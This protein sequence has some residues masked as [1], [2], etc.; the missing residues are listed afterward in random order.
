MF[1]A[2]SKLPLMA[3]DKERK[4]MTARNLL[5]GAAVL[6][7]VIGLGPPAKADVITQSLSVGNSAISPYAG[8]Y[9]TLTVDLTS[10]N[11][12]QITFTSDVVDGNIFLMG[13][14]GQGAVALNVN[15]TSFAVSNISG[16]NS[17]TG[18][19]PGPYSLNSPPGTSSMDGFGDFNLAINSFDGF[20]HSASTITF[21]ITDDS[22]TWSSAS[23]V[24]A[25]NA[26]GGDAATHT[27]VTTYPA[28]A[29]NMAVATG[30]AGNGPDLPVPEP[31]T[32][33]LFGAAILGL[34]M[35][36]QKTRKT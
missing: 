23:D 27:F 34:G 33:A 24:L 11:I 35:I 18:F 16:S 31:G 13:D 15:S 6:A 36:H 12:A 2:I 22:G 9:Q 29:G 8:P 19:T 10:P 3:I 21:D 20:T 25:N 32:L 14:D 17:G 1:A 26:N 30:F 5:A 28:N 7:L 4:L